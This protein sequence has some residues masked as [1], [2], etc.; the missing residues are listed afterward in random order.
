MDLI[1]GAYVQV[2]DSLMTI[3]KLDAEDDNVR[4]DEL[5]IN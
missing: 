3:W 2:R 4:R 5:I 1:V